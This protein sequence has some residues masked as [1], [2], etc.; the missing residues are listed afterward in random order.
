MHTPSK[1]VFFNYRGTS[2]RTNVDLRKTFIGLD[3]PKSV[4]AYIYLVG[5]YHRNDGKD[6]PV[7]KHGEELPLLFI[8]NNVLLLSNNFSFL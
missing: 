8:V 5:K 6:T 4:A 2:K 7:F 3:D 1:K